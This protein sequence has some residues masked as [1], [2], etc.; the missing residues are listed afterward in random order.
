MNMQFS[1]LI[2]IS[3]PAYAVT[4]ASTVEFSSKHAWS[5]GYGNLLST[6]FAGRVEQLAASVRL[7]VCLFVCPA[8]LFSLGLLNSQIFE[9]EFLCV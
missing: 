1:W 4:L 8:R 6:P 2:Y 3:L 7:S 9:F 5:F